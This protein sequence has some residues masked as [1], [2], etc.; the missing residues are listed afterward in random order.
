M[1]SQAG[2]IRAVALDLDGTLVDS[3]PDI[4]HALNAALQQSGLARADLAQVR[5]WI[6]DGPDVLI[7]RALHALGQAS[8]E[9]LHATL[10]RAFDQTTLSAPLTHGLVFAGVPD[11]LQQLAKLCPMVV[12]TN[13]P[14][15]LARAVLHAGALLPH[16]AAVYG[17]DEPAWR[18][19][20]PAL[21]QRAAQ[22]LG[23]A[24]HEL[25]MVGDSGADLRAAAAAGCPAA[26][27]SWGYGGLPPPDAEPQWRIQLPQQ[28]LRIVASG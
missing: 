6:G 9:A 10:R 26:W 27:V 28:L 25:L 16:F 19:P 15:A 17:A 22:A 24:T 12:V 5:D 14:T 23:V 3:A 20:S 18:K 7:D 11:L 4:G 2:S 8:S 13:K 1:T 21:L